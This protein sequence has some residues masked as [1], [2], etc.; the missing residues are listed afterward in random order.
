MSLKSNS[1][2]PNQELVKE[3]SEE[4]WARILS[5]D[6]VLAARR[7]AEKEFTDL[8]SDDISYLRWRAKNDLFYLSNSVLGYSK[9]STGLHGHIVS[10]INDTRYDLYRLMLLPRVHY[11]TTVITISD[12]IQIALPDVDNNHQSPF[13]LGPDV[14][15]LLGHESH[16]GASRFLF[17]ITSHFMSNP[18]L[19][20]LFPECIP[21]PKRQ[22][23]N[24]HELE[25]PR[26]EHWA[27]PT[28]D[29]LGVGAKSQGRH[30]NF[31]K[32]DDI[33]G[34]KARDS[35]AER[36]TTIQW[37]D[38]IQAFLVDL[39]DGHIDLIGTRYSLDDVYHHAIKTY[40]DDLVKYI[41]RVEEI[42]NGKLQPIFPE[43]IQPRQLNILRQNPKV[44]VQYTND[45]VSGLTHFEQGWKRFFEW[46]SGKRLAV[47]SGSN[48]TIVN[49]NDCD[50]CLLLD[51]ARTRKHGL[52]VTAMDPKGRIF[53]LEAIKG[54]YR[55]PE[56][57]N[58]IF[59]L[60]QRW[61]PRTVAIEDV[62]FSSLYQPWFEAEMKLRGVRFNVQT[63]KRKRVGRE[64]EAKEDHVKALANYF[65]AGLVFFHD[66]QNELIEEYDSFGATDDY[67]ILDAMAYGPQVWRPG[68]TADH[69][70]SIRE[71]DEAMMDQRDP[72]TGY[73]M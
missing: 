54:A 63:V 22:R 58:L 10:W 33:F 45:P 46:L 15:L 20:A 37:F 50:I 16:T 49:T 44:W 27:E 19:M 4:D 59:R 36:E 2:L 12:S 1:L 72:L 48:K 66:S 26:N 39:I 60:V 65:S 64:Q 35:R 68:V 17:E 62:I 8:T 51:P 24:Q 43:R 73:S 6:N 28:F 55:D 70:K 71:A 40:G 53:V 5:P 9:L 29:T 67:H 57:A 14:R 23:M 52:V 34:D 7:K 61:W 41:R 13:N 31:I 21:T 30:Y 47:F 3:P 38:N 32:L 18:K 11:K 69:W 25:L 56:L 42:Q